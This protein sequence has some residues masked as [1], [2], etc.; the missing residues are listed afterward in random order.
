MTVRDA[1]LVTRE[2]PRS[3]YPVVDKEQKVLGTIARE[4]FYEFL[5]RRD[6]QPESCL[7]E[8]TFAAVPTVTNDTSVSDVMKCFIRS[9]STKVLVVDQNRRLEGIATVM[10]LMTADG[11]NG[12]S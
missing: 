2:H 5:K 4:D 3:S 6:T 12:K 1:L 9:G 10:D 7:K 8:M 11:G